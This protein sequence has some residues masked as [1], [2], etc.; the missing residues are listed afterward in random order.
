MDLRLFK[1]HV[2]WNICERAET[3]TKQLMLLFII[4]NI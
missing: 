1:S 4:I 2:P 3:D